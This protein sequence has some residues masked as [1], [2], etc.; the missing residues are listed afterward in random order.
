MAVQ[1]LSTMLPQWCEWMQNRCF[2]ATAPTATPTT[3][4]LLEPP[5]HFPLL[6]G[7]TIQLFTVT[8]DSTGN[9]AA[10]FATW[11]RRIATTVQTQV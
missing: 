6:I 3:G 7:F 9:P 8:N 11:I 2:Q 4:A 1:T 5:S 10:G